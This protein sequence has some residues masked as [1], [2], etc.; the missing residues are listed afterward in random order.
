MRGPKSCW[1][2]RVCAGRTSFP[3][4]AA[5]LRGLIPSRSRQLLPLR[6]SADWACPTDLFRR[7]FSLLDIASRFVIMTKWTLD[8]S[9]N[10]HLV[11]AMGAKFEKGVRACLL[12]IRGC[13]QLK[14]HA[15][16]VNPARR[17]RIGRGKY[18][19]VL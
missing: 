14:T 3:A 2:R 6:Q 17:G 10:V 15:G 9:L 13:A 1:S 5:S 19:S 8:S 11:P 7:V 12:R 16:R 4:L 18:A